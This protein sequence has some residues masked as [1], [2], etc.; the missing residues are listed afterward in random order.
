MTEQKNYKKSY[1]KA[2]YTID[3]NDGG[4]DNMSNMSMKDY[5]ISNKVS[6]KIKYYY[7]FTRGKNVGVLN[8]RMTN[9]NPESSIIICDKTDND[10]VYNIIGVDD[11]DKLDRSRNIHEII[12]GHVPRLMM[13][14]IDVDCSMKTSSSGSD[15]GKKINKAESKKIYDSIIS[16][17]REYSLENGVGVYYVVATRHR[18]GKYSWHVICPS[19]YCVNAA[20]MKEVLI[21]VRD[22]INPASYRNYLDICVANNNASMS[23]IGFSNKGYKLSIDDKYTNNNIDDNYKKDDCFNYNVK[24]CCNYLN[25]KIR[26]MEVEINTVDNK[27]YIFRI[28]GDSIFK[29][30]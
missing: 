24:I 28:C 20:H 14:D 29:F 15:S 26:Y 18:R 4:G 12:L 11:F 1:K 6:E 8:S 17:W 7:L 2:K 22:R 27:Y 3:M 30:N 21:N 5:I 13:F 25:R 16:A 9:Y 23:M 19:V 10:H